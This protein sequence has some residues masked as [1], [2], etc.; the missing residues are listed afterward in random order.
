MPASALTITIPG[1]PT[2]QGRGRIIVRRNSGKRGIKD[3]ERSRSWKGVA[4]VHYMN[5]LRQA[6]LERPVF[7]TGVA[8]ELHVLAVFA[9]PK[10]DHRKH[11]PRPRRPHAKDQGD[12]SNV[13]KAVEDAGNGILWFDDC[14]V[15]RVTV[16]KVI[17]AQ[18]EA[19][20]VTVTVR[21]LAWN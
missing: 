3:P 11:E 16:E 20:S 21:E 12:A 10:S 19:P 1:A 13:L 5:A 8:V 14:Q 15:A 9:C 6:G 2:P 17:A 18:G 4:Q 7:G